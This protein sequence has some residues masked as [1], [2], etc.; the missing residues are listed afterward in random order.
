MSPQI[1]VPAMKSDYPIFTEAVF[2]LGR[3]YVR[4]AGTGA[5]G[6]HNNN[7]LK[8]SSV[9]IL[10]CVGG[11]TT[12]LSRYTTTISWSQKRTCNERCLES[13]LCHTASTKLELVQGIWSSSIDPTLWYTLNSW[14]R[15]LME[16]TLETGPNPILRYELRDAFSGVLSELTGNFVNNLHT[17]AQRY[18][19][20]PT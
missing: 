2:G 3:D 15:S 16:V 18:E 4:G 7:A 9:N 14:P 19:L 11:S 17:M 8:S 10:F 12:T 1:L 20:I 5:G 13:P 6:I